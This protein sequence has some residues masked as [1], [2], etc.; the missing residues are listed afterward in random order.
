VTTAK[1][2]MRGVVGGFAAPY[3]HYGIAVRYCKRRGEVGEPG[4]AITSVPPRP[5]RARPAIPATFLGI[6]LPL[7]QSRH[8]GL[9]NDAERT[10]VKLNLLTTGSIADGRNLSARGLPRRSWDW[11]KARGQPVIQNLTPCLSPPA[12][13]YRACSRIMT[14]TLR[15]AGLDAVRVSA[16]PRRDSGGPHTGA[17]Q[18]GFEVTQ[19]SVQTWER[20]SCLVQPGRH[21]SCQVP[22]G[23]RP[24]CVGRPG[25]HPSCPDHPGDHPSCLDH[26]EDR[27][28]CADRPGDRPSCPAH[29]EDHPSSARRARRLPA[30]VR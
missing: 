28:S 12:L 26:P 20:P 10:S 3:W 16:E 11:K 25:V 15:L 8:G 22:P 30:P 27:P 5:R 14:R 29:P 7:S 4:R 1:G 24:S 13:R 9:P 21:P 2:F 23:E 18:V 19:S 17:R 6:R